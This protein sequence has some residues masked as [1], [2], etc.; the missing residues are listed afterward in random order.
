[1]NS[2]LYRLLVAPALAGALLS[3]SL[4]GVQGTAEAAGPRFKPPAKHLKPAGTDCSNVA[5]ADD[6]FQANVA[7]FGLN[8]VQQT[9]A[10]HQNATNEIRDIRIFER[11]NHF[12]Q[13]NININDNKLR[14]G[15]P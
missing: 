1:M 3:V 11:D 14:L 8:F 13:A 7:L 6:E 15:A 10:T 4:M 5:K 9:Q 12:I 2:K